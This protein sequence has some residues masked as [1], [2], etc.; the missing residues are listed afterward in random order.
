MATGAFNANARNFRPLTLLQHPARTRLHYTDI[1]EWLDSITGCSAP[2][3]KHNW[4]DG[5][6]EKRDD[7]TSWITDKPDTD[8]DTFYNVA[9]GLLLQNDRL[10]YRPELLK[11]LTEAAPHA[12]WAVFCSPWAWS[13]EAYDWG[14]EWELVLRKCAWIFNGYPVDQYAVCIPTTPDTTGEF[15][16]HWD[17]PYRW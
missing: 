4:V 11:F 9:V 2:L 1:D 3:T 6:C 16:I 5:P 7:P 10:R 12:L 17:I 13:W 14:M 8:I 15:A